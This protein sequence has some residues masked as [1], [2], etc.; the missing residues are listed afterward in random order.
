[1]AECIFAMWSNP[2]ERREQ[3]LRANQYVDQNNWEAKR[4]EYLRL[5]DT[6]TLRH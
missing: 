4:G 2:D 3:V 5:V 6:L 1:L